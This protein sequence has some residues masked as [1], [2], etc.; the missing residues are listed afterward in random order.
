MSR[1][2][3]HRLVRRSLAQARVVNANSGSATEVVDQDLELHRWARRELVDAGHI[4]LRSLDAGRGL[5]VGQCSPAEQA[6]LFAGA[7]R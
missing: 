1:T 7:F 3:L 6:E 4:W 5:E 2:P